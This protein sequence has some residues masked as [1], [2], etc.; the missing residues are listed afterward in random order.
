MGVRQ[1]SRRDFEHQLADRVGV[2]GEFVDDA[3]E[4][5]DR[6]S[7]GGPAVGKACADVTGGLADYG[8]RCGLIKGLEI[9]V[10]ECGE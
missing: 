8:A 1:V 10:G 7:A 4:V 2:G 6:G 3:A 5:G 9:A